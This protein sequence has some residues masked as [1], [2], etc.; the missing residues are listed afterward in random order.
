[1]SK[2]QPKKNNIH[3]QYRQILEMPHLTNE[4]ID[5]MRPHILL[6]ARTICEHVW[7][8]EFY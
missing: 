2:S 8:K 6:L 1:M 3:D 5:Q 4:E 7:G